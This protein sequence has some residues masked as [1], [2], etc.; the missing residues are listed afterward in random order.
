V[1]FSDSLKSNVTLRQHRILLSFPSQSTATQQQQQQ[2]HT[3]ISSKIHHKHIQ[4]LRSPLETRSVHGAVHP[5][6][7]VSE[8]AVAESSQEYFDAL[9]AALL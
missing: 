1:S 9:A 8:G 3:H 5:G 4:R 7:V 6:C 2:Q